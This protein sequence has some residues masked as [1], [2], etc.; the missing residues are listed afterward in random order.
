VQIFTY[1][2]LCELTGPRTHAAS[3]E[4]Y[5]S[6]A[7]GNYGWKILISSD[8]EELRKKLAAEIASSRLAMVA[9]LGMFYQDGLTGSSWCDWAP[10]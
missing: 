3:L 8:P 4:D 7:P 9:I 6:I 10:H 2:G 1:A 5:A